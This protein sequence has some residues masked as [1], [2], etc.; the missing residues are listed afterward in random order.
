M[1]HERAIKV[2]KAQAEI[3]ESQAR[4]WQSVAPPGWEAHHERCIEVAASLRAA[5]AVL[6]REGKSE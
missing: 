3:R 6:E 1:R 4:S 5:V 2:L